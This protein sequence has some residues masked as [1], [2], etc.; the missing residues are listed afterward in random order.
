MKKASQSFWRTRAVCD[1]LGRT[2]RLPP[3]PS[4][5]ID[6]VTGVEKK[7]TVFKRL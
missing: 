2:D 5:M 4:A 7:V 1:Q 3:T 6:Y